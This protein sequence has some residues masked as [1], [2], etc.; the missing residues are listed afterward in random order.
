[1]KV[2]LPV[3]GSDIG[4]EA[5][6]FVR[7]LATWTP[8]DVTVL[9]IWYDPTHDKM[10]PW[11][12][13][14]KEYENNRTQK[15]LDNANN[16]LQDVCSS[17]TL[18]CEA[19]SAAYA[20]LERAKLSEVDLIVMGAKGHSTISRWLIG[21]VSDTV[22]TNAKCSVVVVRPAVERKKATE[23]I[24]LGFDQSVASR[25]AVSELLQCEL[26]RDSEIDVVSIVVNP[27]QYGGDAMVV[28]FTLDPEQ[29][30]KIDQAAER[31]A[32]QIS[33]HFPHTKVATSAADH[34]G[35]AIVAKAEQEKTTLVVL[36]DS[37]Q[38]LFG[39]FLLGSTS[40]YVLRHAKCSVWISRHH[41][42]AQKK[43]IEVENAVAAK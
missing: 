2:L 29:V 43:S 25:E 34:V 42:N 3:D 11:A 6:E 21:S 19:G 12:S 18:L 36:G 13:D 15:A 1:M 22:A 17:V 14:W 27:T 31:M 16:R 28:P 26:P 24:L 38:G 4:N 20:I 39:H 10:Q 35:Q 8:A 40:K 33:E 32:S 41:W 23:K 7:S 5:V 37:G 30:E 9:A